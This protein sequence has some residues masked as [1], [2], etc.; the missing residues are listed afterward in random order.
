MSFLRTHAFHALSD[1]MDRYK[2][3]VRFVYR[4]FPLVDLHPWAMRA[5]VDANC[6]AAQS[7]ETYWKFVDYIHAHGQEVSGEDRD[8]QKSFSALDRIAREEATLAKLDSV[9][10]NA[11]L[12]KQDDARV[13]ASA[14][15]A[16]ALG[17][18]GTPACLSTENASAAL[19]LPNRSGWSLT[20]P[21]ALPELN[22]RL[23]PRPSR[24]RPRKASKNAGDTLLWPVLS[25]K[26]VSKR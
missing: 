9:K 5:A 1:T 16:E 6:L 17:V 12:A 14:K 8:L 25:R 2:D 20:G 26:F 10:L 22:L 19:F 18:D 24:R 23:R 15:E 3:K 21:F 7:D 11:C 4:D 13:R